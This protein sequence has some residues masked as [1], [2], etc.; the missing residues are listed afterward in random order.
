MLWH[1]RQAHAGTICEL[2]WDYRESRTT[3]KT[4][5]TMRRALAPSG[6]CSSSCSTLL[7]ANAC[8]NP[9]VYY[10]A[11]RMLPGKTVVKHQPVSSLTQSFGLCFATFKVRNLQ[12]LA[13]EAGRHQSAQT[14]TRAQRCTRV[15]VMN[16]LFTLKLNLRSI[17]ICI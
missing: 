10:S 15:S 4:A 8:C 12:P 17:H 16:G 13:V 14:C 9:T 7:F 6:A 1:E 11:L 3:Y 2:A 5:L